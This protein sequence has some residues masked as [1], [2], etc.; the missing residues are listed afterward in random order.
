[1]V[2]AFLYL[3][4]LLPPPPSTPHKDRK[5][6]F[7]RQIWKVGGKVDPNCH[8]KPALHGQSSFST[9]LMLFI[10]FGQ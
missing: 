1:M 2:K 6:R 5:S 7:T 3:G 10:S 4:V 9:A 8:C